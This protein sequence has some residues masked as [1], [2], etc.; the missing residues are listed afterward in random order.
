MQ[1]PVRRAAGIELESSRH[2]VAGHA[3]AQLQHLGTVDPAR[4]VKFILGDVTDTSLWSDATLV[5]MLCTCFPEEVLGAVAA[6]VA[7][8]PPGTRLVAAS[9]EI[10]LP[11]LAAGARPPGQLQLR[12]RLVLPTT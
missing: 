6:G 2:D 10:H 7:A 4:E 11:A 3:L 5:F 9:F 8:L 12:D 1:T